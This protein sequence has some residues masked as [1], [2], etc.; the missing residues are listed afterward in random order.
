[1][2]NR[3]MPRL[4]AGLLA[5]AIITGCEAGRDRKTVRQA[6]APA[7]TAP[8]ETSVVVRH[9][10]RSS[11][12]KSSDAVRGGCTAIAELLRN[13]ALAVGAGVS[14]VAAPRDT[15]D[16]FPAANS[17]GPEAA[18]VVAWRD[19]TRESPLGEVYERLD[20]SGWRR[21]VELVQADGPGSQ[22]VA[23]SRGGAA[24]IVGGSWDVEDDSDSTY[25]PKPGF[26]I[27]ATCFH[28][29]PDP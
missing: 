25:V 21:R 2:L 1:M 17:D 12:P 28:D 10:V 20:L 26:A 13:E 16:V 18:C 4:T 15:T 23:F 14:A 22:A 6:G 5:L 19:S 29:R 27:E 7:D 24:C 11:P 3:R 9:P 8:A